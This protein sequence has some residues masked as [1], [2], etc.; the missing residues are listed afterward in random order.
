MQMQQA[1]LASLASQTLLQKMGHAFWDAFSGQSSS[2]S[3]P[4]SWDAEK[5][6]KVL[7]GSAVLKVVDV[8]PQAKAKAPVASAEVALEDS[9]HRM[10]L[11]GGSSSKEK[12]P[13]CFLSRA[14]KSKVSC[15]KT[16]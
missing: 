4:K 5:V 7:D 8:E 16:A 9:L 3:S 14:A 2:S 1:M 10:S 6:R 15:A 13:L 11:G 12:D